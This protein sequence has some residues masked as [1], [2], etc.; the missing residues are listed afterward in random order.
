MTVAP[1]VVDE[2]GGQCPCQATGSFFGFPFYFR[3]RHGEWG[4]N[5]VR[6]GGDPVVSLDL[7]YSASGGDA[8]HGSMAPW[9]A[10]AILCAHWKIFVERGIHTR[11]DSD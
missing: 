1:F 2:I 3:A 10:L 6:P 11:N 7:V 5:V 4:L 8:E 9:T